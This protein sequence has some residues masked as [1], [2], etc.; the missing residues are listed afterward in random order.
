MPLDGAHACAGALA[1]ER[2]HVLR[3]E[4]A[5]ALEAAAARGRAQVAALQ[6]VALLTP[7]QASSTSVA[8]QRMRSRPEKHAMVTIMQRFLAATMCYHVI[9]VLASCP[10]LDLDCFQHHAL[11]WTGLFS[12]PAGCRG[13][14]GALR[15]GAGGSTRYC[16]FSTGPHH[17]VRLVPP[18]WAGPIRVGSISVMCKPLLSMQWGLSHSAEHHCVPLSSQAACKPWA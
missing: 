14:R 8:A 13:C 9:W 18:P 10:C 4:A 3:V 11:A 12:A 17:L 2:E 16:C 6:Q 1:G 15:K 7:V 5:A